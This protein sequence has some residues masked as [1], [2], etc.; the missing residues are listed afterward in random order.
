MTDSENKNAPRSV[1]SRP[2]ARALLR[3]G[4]DSLLLVVRD[5]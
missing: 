5:D 2:V 4:R 3:L 1:I